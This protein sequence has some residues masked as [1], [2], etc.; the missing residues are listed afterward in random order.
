MYLPNEEL[1]WK[2]YKWK[3]MFLTKRAIQ[4][5]F[6]CY[7]TIPIIYIITWFLRSILQRIIFS[8]FSK[9]SDAI[10][11]SNAINFLTR[12]FEIRF[13]LNYELGLY[14]TIIVSVIHNYREWLRYIWLFL[15]TFV[16]QQKGYNLHKKYGNISFLN[17]IVTTK[18]KC[19]VLIA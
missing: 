10:L 3:N 8:F 15:T 18:K 5:V 4:K 16:K 7:S 1:K 17:G 12:T 6:H 19:F 11:N 14:K 2:I 13:I 9:L